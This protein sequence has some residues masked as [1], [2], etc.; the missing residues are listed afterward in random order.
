MMQPAKE[1]ESH[2]DQA[3]VLAFLGES[4]HGQLPKRIDTH[5]SIVF[6][7]PDRVLKVKRSVRLPFLD[8]STLDKRKRACEEELA[9]NRHYAPQLYRRVVPITCDNG[10][11]EIDGHG[12]PIE[13]ALEMARFDETKAL[14][15]LCASGSVS[16]DLGD[17][18]GDVMLASHE[19]AEISDG[20]TWLPS[21]YGIIDRNTEKF[22]SQATLTRGAV[23]QL[24]AL[25]HRQLTANRDLLRRR[26]TAGLVR[27]CHG[28]AHLG[29]I[30]LIDERP[31]LFDAIEFDPAIANIDVLYDLAFPIMDFLHFS[32]VITANRLFNHYLR[33]T[34]R[35][36]GDA[37]R[38]FPLFLSIRAAIRS[39]VLFTKYE[40]AATEASIATEAKSYFEL[41]LHLIKDTRPS[42]VAIGGRSGTG[43]TVLA[44]NLAGL[45]SPSPGAVVL[46]S[47]L[48]RKEMFGVDDF[49]ALPESAYCS[50]ISER[51]YR[52]MIERARDII[53]QGFSAVLD[54]AFLQERER[55]AAALAARQSDAS[56]R[57]IFLT[58]DSVVRQSRV[59]ARRR[60]ASDATQAVAARQEGMDIGQ[61]NWPI[62]DASGSPEQTL[63]RSAAKIR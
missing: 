29:N 38:L 3:T 61:L 52:I 2:S 57:P 40:Q 6:L 42:L 25:S 50:D 48:I 14:D 11:M 46:R 8:Y 51:V 56:F 43:K 58:A 22:R 49:V 4:K 39:H 62:V 17:Q 30:V 63:E 55:D 13:W 41:A 28:D 10:R 47:D 16:S 5:I 45:L 19:R 9:V 35:S 53:A 54:A 24:H 15:E 20:S 59:A 21:I 26:A 32:Q 27:R 36:N 34:W 7:E 44:R 37:L 18:L 33:K 1:S 60:D 23:E 31:V 12:V